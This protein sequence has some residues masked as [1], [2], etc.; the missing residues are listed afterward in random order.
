M[1]RPRL[2]FGAFCIVALLLILSFATLADG[3][4]LPD[5]PSAGWLTIVYHDVTVTIRDGVVTTH[6]DQV[7]RNDT[8][9]DVEGRYVFPLPQGAV[10]SAFTMWVDGEPVTAEVFEAEEARAIYE[11]YVRR[12]VDPA[13]LEYVGRDTLEARI[14]PIP[15]GRERRIQI[16]YSEMIVADSGVYR[17]RYPLDTERFSARPL[18][19]VQIRIDVETTRPLSAL[20]S[21]TH[22]VTVQRTSERTATC[23]YDARDVLPSQDFWLYYAVSDDVLGMTLVTYNGPDDDGY[24]LLVVTPPALPSDSE[25]LPKDIVLVLDQSG[26]MSGDKIEQA[27]EALLFILDNLNPSDRFALVSFSDDARTLTDGLTA[28]SADAVAAARGQIAA[29]SA[30]GMT[31]IDQALSVALALFE[32]NERPRF[33]IFLT[34]GEPTVGEQDPLAIAENAFAANSTAARLFTFGVGYDVNT[35]LLDKLA[36][37]NRGNTTYVLP[38]E[39]LEA[40]LS[41]FYRTIA[42]PALANPVLEIDGVEIFDVF[43]RQLSDIFHGSQLLVLGRYRAENDVTAIVGISGDVEGVATAYTS[44]QRFSATALDA[45]FL[46]RLW[47]GRMI[48][49][50]LDQIRLYGESDEVIDE[51]IRLSRQYGII[52]P[53][54]SFLV[55]EGQDMDA[56]EMADAVRQAATPAVGANAVSGSSALKTLAESETVQEGVDQIQIVGSRTYFLRNGTWIDAEYADEETIDVVVYSGA[57]FE[58]L[59]RFPEIAPHLAIGEDIVLL[60]GDRFVHI[61]AEGAEELTESIVD[62][63]Q[64]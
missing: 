48:A 32:T 27:K 51:V 63:L 39:N 35:V 37:E 49:V 16:E 34:D 5:D 19:R 41:S 22:T 64:G 56:E 62:Q 1:I 50:L 33:L 20:Y 30:G 15:A 59:R 28:V 43:P 40:R 23:V 13:L 61:G 4:I 38:G 2:P 24:F 53:Y 44:T 55:D 58:L 25:I 3:M 52:T 12:A 7:F 31:N 18:A 45:S 17:Y 14:Y 8:G 57:Y 21:P 26:S 54:T 42:S 29:I 60:I 11:D 6:V 10:V 9:V 36:L 46:P 47:A